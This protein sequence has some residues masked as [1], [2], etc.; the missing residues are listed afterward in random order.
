VS[1]AGSSCSPAAAPAADASSPRRSVSRRSERDPALLWTAALMR[2]HAGQALTLRRVDAGGE[3]PD[4][5]G[6]ASSSIASRAS[7]ACVEVV[8]VILD[9]DPC[10]SARRGHL[11]LSPRLKL[12]IHPLVVA[13]LTRGLLEE[14]FGPRDWQ[15]RAPLN[16][17]H[18]LKQQLAHG[19]SPLAVVVGVDGNF[20]SQF[21]SADATEALWGTVR[22]ACR[23]GARQPAA[24][25]PSLASLRDETRSSGVWCLGI[26]TPSDTTIVVATSPQPARASAPAQELHPRAA[27]RNR[28]HSIEPRHASSRAALV[29]TRL[30]PPPKSAEL[31]AR[32]TVN[33]SMATP[34]DFV[35]R[36]Q[37]ID[38]SA[39]AL[40][41]STAEKRG[42]GAEDWP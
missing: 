5:R 16:L 36:S 23:P 28:R 24:E 38:F 6:S 27:H 7:E 20:A 11:L 2:R 41:P 17:V 22:W 30:G 4:M 15:R 37:G 33:R 31:K 12:P 10:A 19:S 35:S 26:E 14:A 9:Q 34:T 32:D 42:R 18:Q 29:P 1:S 39:L 21:A 25:T 13:P 40:A 8:D 3:T